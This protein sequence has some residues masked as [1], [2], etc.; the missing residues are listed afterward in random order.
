MTDADY[1]VLTVMGEASGEPVEGRLAVACVIRNRLHSGRWGGT[2]ESVCLAD[3]QFSCWSPAGGDANYRRVIA[4]RSKV[5]R[6][7]VIEDPV[8]AETRWVVDGVMRGIVIDRVKAATHYFA[9]SEPEVPKWAKGQVPVA[10]VGG[11]I[12]FS[13]IK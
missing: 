5:F 4:L 3:R 10:R 13:G 7:E 1:A 2:Y 12:F 11:H 8:F 9:A 6:G